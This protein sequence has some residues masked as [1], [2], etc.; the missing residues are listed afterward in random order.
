MYKIKGL[1]L[2]F[3]VIFT[4]YI[5]TYKIGI[6]A[7]FILII[8]LILFWIAYLILKSREHTKKLNEAGQANLGS[9]SGYAVRQKKIQTGLKGVRINK[10]Q[11][12]EHKKPV[13]ID[14]TQ[15][16][17]KKKTQ[18][19]Q[20]KPV[21]PDSYQI[22]DAELAIAYAQATTGQEKRQIKEELDALREV[23]KGINQKSLQEQL[24]LLAI[25]IRGVKRAKKRLESRADLRAIKLE[26][27]LTQLKNEYDAIS[28][29]KLSAGNSRINSSNGSKQ[30]RRSAT[31]GNPRK[32]LRA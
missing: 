31:K 24:K 22:A 1:A 3:P 30:R 26:K 15:L 7:I 9:K 16:Q 18:Q 20:Q 27:L 6:F 19:I 25:A 4:L 13:Q 11:Q 2:M 28:D 23:K 29:Q 17:G 32:R 5:F 14:V 8:L 21:K 10:Q 12:K